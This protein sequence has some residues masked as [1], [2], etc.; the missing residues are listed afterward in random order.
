MPDER[1]FFEKLKTGDVIPND[2]T[3][4]IRVYHAKKK[5][6]GKLLTQCHR[7][8]QYYPEGM[9]QEHA[10]KCLPKRIPAKQSK[11]KWHKRALRKAMREADKAGKLAE[12]IEKL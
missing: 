7:C 8:G 1:P 3:V 9:E 10:P 6:R 5:V 11:K 2:Q 4:T 12:F